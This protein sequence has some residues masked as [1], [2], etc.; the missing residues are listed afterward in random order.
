MSLLSTF[1]ILFD[2]D[3]KKATSETD[4]LSKALD[5]VEESA[6]G[7]TGG[8][9]G[10]TESYNES[11]V[12]IGA[13]TKSM[14]GMI[15]AYVTFDAIASKIIDNATS[16]D[17]MGKFTQTLGFNIAEMDAWGTAAE[18]NGGSAEAFRGTIESLQT[19]LQDME[20]T[21]GGEMINTLAMIGI[22]ATGAGGK[23]KSAF[24]ILPE[25]AEAFKNMSTAKSFA[26]GKK[27]GLDQGT[28]LTLQQSRYEVDKLVERQKLLSGV[29]K[30]GYEQA[31]LFNDQWD[32]TKRV[33]NSLWMSANSTIL[34]LLQSFL[35]GLEVIVLWVREN[36]SLVEG[37]FIGVAG[38]IAAVY[39]PAISSAAAA[40]LIA[41]APFVLVG[42]AI[43]AVGFAVALLYEDIQA[44]VSGSKSALGEIVGKFDDFKDKITDVFDTISKKWADFI[45]FFTDTKKDITDFLDLS[46]VFSG[47]L[48]I[49]S[50]FTQQGFNPESQTLSNTERAQAMIDFYSA[51]QLN[52]GGNTMNQ[53]TQN[54]NVNVGGANIN[55]SGMSQQQA[56]QTFNDGLKQNIE[57]AIGQLDDGVDR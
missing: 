8:V 40:T 33:F 10:S 41:I 31:A 2:T 22:Q 30:E 6:T 57:M 48:S 9:D 56:S 29:T 51:T 42:A 1:S 37:F 34:P 44:W 32:D 12:S 55:A 45:K 54:V 17:S 47:G 24:E 7:A 16:I 36:Q 53:R 50:G 39:L 23:V 14:M 26:F 35:K 43:A 20:I 3:A 18:R 52:Q 15:A 38:A 11:T 21:G 13:L 46:N 28:I 49:Q 19:S 5:D 27:L 4:G 25:I